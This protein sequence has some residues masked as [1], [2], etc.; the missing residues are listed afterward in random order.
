[1]ILCD[2]DYRVARMEVV[3]DGH[4][5]AAFD[6]DPVKMAIISYICVLAET[7]LMIYSKTFSISSETAFC[8]ARQAEGL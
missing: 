5:A 2:E 6:G 4:L 7:A 8:A 1:M 3:P